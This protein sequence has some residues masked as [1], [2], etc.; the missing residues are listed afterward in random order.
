MTTAAKKTAAP[1]KRPAVKA[2]SVPQ[3]AEQTA[4]AT[5]VDPDVYVPPTGLSEGFQGDGSVTLAR[6]MTRRALGNT[7]ELARSANTEA[8]RKYWNNS[9]RTSGVLNGPDLSPVL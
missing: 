9:L 2:V 6:K 5:P 1:R 8:G 4:P 7:V 3:T